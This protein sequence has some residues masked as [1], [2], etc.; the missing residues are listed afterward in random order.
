MMLPYLV[1]HIKIMKVA[2]YCSSKNDIASHHVENANIV[3]K[4]IGINKATLIYGGIN[5]GLMKEV[6][7]VA[8]S[9]GAKV[10]GIVPV[11]RKNNTFLRNDENIIVDDLN[12]RKA[13]MIMLADAFIVLAGG[14]G[15]LDEF[16]STLTSLSFA[17]DKTKSIIVLNYGGLFD[18]TMAQLKL[19]AQNGLMNHDIL[20]RVKIAT[21]A[22]ECCNLLNQC[23]SHLK[24]IQK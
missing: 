9:H 20:Q 6:A 8:K 24:S 13:K 19:M 23:K 5:L 3:G 15:T 17:N 18:H 14:Y 16:I 7:D 10:V 11:S 1:K 22:T 21:T 4:W 2:V 12:D